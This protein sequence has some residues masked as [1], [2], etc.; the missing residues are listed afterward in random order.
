LNINPQF[1]F[2]ISEIRHS[3]FYKKHSKVEEPQ[4][5]LP[6][7]SIPIDESVFQYMVQKEGYEELSL[8]KNLM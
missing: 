6:H 4:G 1:R 2:S 3:V 8:R 7:H 5:L